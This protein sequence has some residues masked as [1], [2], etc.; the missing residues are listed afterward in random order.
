MDSKDLQS[1]LR[2]AAMVPGVNVPKVSEVPAEIME[3]AI[4]VTE[5]N[6]EN[7][8]ERVKEAMEGEFADRFLK[9]MRDLPGRD[10]IRIYSKMLE[11]V[12]PKIVRVEGEKEKETENVIRIEIHN[13]LPQQ[14]VID[15]TYK[16]ETNETEEPEVES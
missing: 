15:V 4:E 14:D 6:L 11:Y 10:F 12:K 8:W 16:D 13:S 1:L 3:K 2:E 7:K 9:E 5:S